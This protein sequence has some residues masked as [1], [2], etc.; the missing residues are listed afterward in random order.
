MLVSMLVPGST[1]SPRL[2]L[3]SLCVAALGTEG[4]ALLVCAWAPSPLLVHALQFKDAK[5]IE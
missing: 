5:F 1:W 3:I 4:K 2:A